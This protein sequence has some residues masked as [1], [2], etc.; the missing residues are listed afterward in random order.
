MLLGMPPE[1]PLAFS[2]LDGYFSSLSA[3]FTLQLLR[4]PKQIVMQIIQLSILTIESLQ[5]LYMLQLI[6][7]FS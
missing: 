1:P 6:F 3:Y 7:V 2:W 5:M 4:P